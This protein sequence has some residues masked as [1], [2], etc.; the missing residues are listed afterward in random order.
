MRLTTL[1]GDPLKVAR[2][3]LCHRCENHR[4]AE[5]LYK[6]LKARFDVWYSC[7]GS[8]RIGDRIVPRLELARSD[9][10]LILASADSFHG[11]NVAAAEFSVA[12]VLQIRGQSVLALVALEST[13]VPAE[14]S[15]L[16]FERFRWAKR[17]I[18]GPRILE[19][20]ERRLIRDVGL[21]PKH[22]PDGSEVLAFGSE[23]EPILEFLKSGRATKATPLRL[24]APLLHLEMTNIIEA[25]KTWPAREQTAAVELLQS[26]F[27]TDNHDARGARQ[28]AVFM[29]GKLARG[30]TDVIKNLKRKHPDFDTPFLYRGY[31][32]ALSYTDADVMEE[33]VQGLWRETGR[34]W[35]VQRRLNNNF[36][37]L[38]YR[39]LAGTLNELRSSLR[40]GRP[41]GL[42]RL[43]TFTLGELSNRRSDVS[44]LQN[45]RSRLKLLGV[46][47]SDVSAAA[48]K[49]TARIR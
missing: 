46:P 35:D 17:Q 45:V 39:G 41:H 9:L 48:K 20:V 40:Q 38:Y 24:N 29:L 44:L 33:Y 14:Y 30:N 22:A 12:D 5:Y 1:L 26:M 8:M 16:S 43:N 6:L 42:L 25:V 7:A 10:V 23:I 27:F 31:H 3:F 13:D 49:I 47:D 36:H 32:V 21:E 28:N 11:R 2:V 15:D 34:E 4:E 18:D 37:L 19:A